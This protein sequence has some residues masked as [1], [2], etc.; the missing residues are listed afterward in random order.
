MKRAALLPLLLVTI[1]CA[2]VNELDTIRTTNRSRLLNL[3][4]SMSRGD[5]LKVMG[6]ETKTYHRTDS[7]LE[8]MNNPYRTEMYKSG[9]HQFEILYYYTDVKKRDDAITDDELT[10]LV[11]KDGLLDGWGWSYLTDVAAKY[12]LRIR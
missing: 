7:V 8:T 12:E 4:A 6:T 3:R 10:P 9:E 11:L 1:G 2:T 5:V